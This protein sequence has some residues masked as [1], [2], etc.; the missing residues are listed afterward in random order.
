M[1]SQRG[2]Q[3]LG[4]LFVVAL[5]LLCAPPTFAHDPIRF[6]SRRVVPGA[7]LEI[8]EVSRDATTVRYRVKA[9]GVPRG[10]VTGV[11]ANEFGHGYHQLVADLRVD[12]A[13]DLVSAEP[14]PG[15][16]RKLDDM[17]FEPDALPSGAGWEVAIVTED[18]KIVA[19]A[20]VIPHPIVGR[21]GPCS[22]IGR[23]SCRE[24]V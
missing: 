16:S 12:D 7:T 14:A 8:V 13:G 22:E 23:A 18:R 11:W 21:S 5:A 10:L 17:V 1:A 4:G 2:R 9:S 3:R 24:R 15:G 19:Y 6:D 20:K